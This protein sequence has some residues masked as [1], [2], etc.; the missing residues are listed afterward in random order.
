MPCAFL[1]VSTGPLFEGGPHPSA[2][3]D[4]GG[5]HDLRDNCVSRRARASQHQRKCR[6]EAQ[7]RGV[8]KRRSS[9]RFRSAPCI[10]SGCIEPV[11]RGNAK[12][13]SRHGEQAIRYSSRMGRYV[14]RGRP[15]GW[16]SEFAG[17]GLRVD[18][19]NRSCEL[20]GESYEVAS[21]SLSHDRHSPPR[22]WQRPSL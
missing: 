19:Q 12:P 18:R 7:N 13:R 11:A 5:I 4:K 20:R 10:A 6:S 14:N 2:I 17:Y 21:F 16:G 9:D 3:A 22:R 8:G 15:E 1:R